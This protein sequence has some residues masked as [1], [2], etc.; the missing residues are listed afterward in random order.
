MLFF[1][2]F[3]FFNDTATTEI[4]TL[5]LHDALPIPSWRPRSSSSTEL[6]ASLYC[7]KRVSEGRSEATAMNMPNTKETRPRSSAANRMASKRSR[8][9]RGLEGVLS[10]RS[11]SLIGC[12]AAPLDGRDPAEGLRRGMTL[13]GL[14]P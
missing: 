1:F 13:R 11:S 12:W 4:Y 9:R 10:E 6:R 14:Q 3:F 5:S 7:E 2:L 8:F